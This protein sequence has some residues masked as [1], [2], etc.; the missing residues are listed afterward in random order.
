MLNIQDTLYNM[1]RYHP[2]GGRLYILTDPGYFHDPTSSGCRF[3][4]KM[5]FISQGLVM[6]INKGLSVCAALLLAIFE[7]SNTL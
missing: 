5:G 2:Y 6:S 1:D 3:T 4:L 7:I